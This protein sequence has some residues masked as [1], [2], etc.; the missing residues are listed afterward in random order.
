[1]PSIEQLQYLIKLA[2][3][4]NFRRAAETA[5][6][7][8]PALTKSIKQLEA[9]YGVPLFD[10]RKEGVVPTPYGRVVIERVRALL[11]AFEASKRDVQMLAGLEVGEL[12]VGAAPYST[13]YALP[14][15]LLKM[16]SGMPGMRFRVEVKDPKTLI[17][18]L[19]RSE[20]DLYLGGIHNI[21]IPKN[22][23]VI[24]LPSEDIVVCCRKK[25]PSLR[26]KELK[27]ADI[28]QYPLVG[29]SFHIRF[30]ELLKSMLA[31][32]AA[33]T[34]RIPPL[35][36]ECND[37]GV[38]LSVLEQSDCIGALPRSV[39]RRHIERGTLVELPIKTGIQTKIGIVYLQ[40]R[41]LPPAAQIL[42]DQLKSVFA[43]ETDLN[44]TDHAPAR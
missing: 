30:E 43:S 34:K 24:D 32:Q 26:K 21:D 7:T 25:H 11:G 28:A 15:A 41:T 17:D 23:T 29:P 9:W 10:R 42:I 37:T 3:H 39:L 18:M 38:I 5:C 31:S 19:A 16:I 22:A 35:V 12:R 2:D 14:A 4:G 27:P 36:L 6:I 8:Q 33:P 1:M 44:P 13:S 20:I 40:D